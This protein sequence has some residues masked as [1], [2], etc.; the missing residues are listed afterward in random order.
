MGKSKSYVVLRE[1]ECEE[2]K[3]KSKCKENDEKVSLDWKKKKKRK[4]G[5]RAGSDSV[6]TSALTSTGK[7][8]TWFRISKYWNCWYTSSDQIVNWSNIIPEKYR[9]ELNN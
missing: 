7:D 5:V 9:Y 3:P 4:A 2:K 8:R 1:H 6:E